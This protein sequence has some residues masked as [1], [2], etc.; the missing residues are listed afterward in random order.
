MLDPGNADVPEVDRLIHARH[1]APANVINV[2]CPETFVLGLVDDVADRVDDDDRPDLNAEEVSEDV[3]PENVLGGPAPQPTQPRRDREAAEPA[4]GHEDTLLV[5]ELTLP[6]DTALGYGRARFESLRSRAGALEARLR[7]RVSIDFFIGRIRPRV[8][9]ARAE[10]M[11]ALSARLAAG[12]AL[13]GRLGSV[14]SPHFFH[15]RQS[16]KDRA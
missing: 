11:T 7:E 4:A 8:R 13:G 14:G 12:A 5:D 9:Q 10:R 16:P 6:H 2:V 3:L 1:D 15:C